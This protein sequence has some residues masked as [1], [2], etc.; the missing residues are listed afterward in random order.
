MPRPP[1]YRHPEEF[2][3]VNLSQI[4]REVGRT[5][6][7]TRKL[8]ERVA[9]YVDLHPHIRNRKREDITYDAAAVEIVK[10]MI[11]LPHRTIPGA[12]D[13]LTRFMTGDKDA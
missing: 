7:Q 10:A 1:R 8:L 13:W 4:A 12:N 3:R 9:P 11:G 2:R 6:T 5:R